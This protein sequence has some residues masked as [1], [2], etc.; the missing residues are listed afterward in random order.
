MSI[1]PKLKTFGVSVAL[2]VAIGAALAL[3]ATTRV[4]E[5]LPE[6][7]E[8]EVVPAPA[9][10]PEA[11]DTPPPPA[12]PPPEPEPAPP[13]PVPT[14]KRPERVPEAAKVVK[15]EELTPFQENAPDQPGEREA[16]PDTAAVPAPTVPVI[17]MAT[18]VGTGVSDYISTSSTVGGV[19][20]MAGAGGGRGGAGVGQGAPGELANQGAVGVK[21]SRD[22]QVTALP[23]PLNNDDF[24]PDYPAL[25]R[26]EG[27]EAQVVLEL[28]IDERGIVR[29]VNI[30]DA[31]RD[32][33]FAESARAYGRKLRFRPARA[34]TT[35][36]ASR[37]EWTVSYYVRN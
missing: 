22:W 9:P 28:V 31:P 19:P 26:R 4:I 37:I 14:A 13:P 21:V 29:A 24:E 1:D 15:V 2:H 18:T 34:G 7:I 10:E 11:L 27:R 12:P 3:L 23:E 8:F 35:P 20:V 25:A 30:V 6:I 16:P 36:V 17:D 32:G 33:G 5:R